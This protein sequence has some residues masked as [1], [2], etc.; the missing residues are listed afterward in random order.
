[1]ATVTVD[2][3]GRLPFAER[4]EQLLDYVEQLAK[5]R[6]RHDRDRPPVERFSGTLRGDILITS[7]VFRI[8]RLSA[9]TPPR[10]MGAARAWM[11][12]AQMFTSPVTLTEYVRVKSIDVH[13]VGFR[14]Y[15]WKYWPAQEGRLFICFLRIP[16]LPH[17]DGSLVRVEREGVGPQNPDLTGGR[18]VVSRPGLELRYDFEPW[19]DRL[20]SWIKLFFIRDLHYWRWSRLSGYEE[21]VQ[22]VRSRAPE[23]DR[24]AQTR[25]DAM[26]AEFES[27][28]AELEEEASDVGSRPPMEP[29]KQP[30]YLVRMNPEM[31]LGDAGLLVEQLM[32]VAQADGNSSA[33]YFDRIVRLDSSNPSSER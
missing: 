26:V 18:I 1:M 10:L 23:F 32:A 19:F 31:T 9:N 25:H 11:R 30:V 29:P 7:D 17:L 5:I 20:F 4:Q 6:A 2:Y 22:A 14:L 24:D 8:A 13:G 12:D 16:A 15:D 33:R 28:A 27:L 21:Y 3:F